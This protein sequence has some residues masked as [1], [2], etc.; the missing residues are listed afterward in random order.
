MSE[1][2]RARKQL[3]R[4]LSALLADDPLEEAPKTAATPLEPASTAPIAQLEANPLQ[5][6]KHFDDE[7]LDAL[8]AS[9]REKGLLQPILV[10]HNPRNPD[11]YEI[12]A[13]ERRW[14]AAQRAALHDV[15]IILR[16]FN[17]AETL[18]VAIVENVQRADLNAV[19]EAEGYA[20]LID[21]HGY[22]Q[23]QLAK[24]IGRSRSH[25]SNMI[26]LLKLPTAAL[27]YV[28]QGELSMGHARTL[29]GK[30]DAEALADQIVKRD[31]SVRDAEKLA[32]GDLPAKSRGAKPKQEFEPLDA[33]TAALEADLGA[34]LSAKVKLEHKG[35]G[36]QLVISYTSLDHLDAVCEKLGL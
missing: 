29:I 16:E 22:T 21:N 32:L 33:N 4:G 31:L 30:E 24:V 25:I 26:R 14:R 35:Q 13:G 9:I 15:P 8:A 17:D 36:G 5:P 12:I 19:E 27:D 23:D 11:G 1:V 18:E 3:G 10:R 2:H 7:E 34:L 6:R 28:R 20:S